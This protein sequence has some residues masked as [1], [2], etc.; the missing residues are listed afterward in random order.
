MRTLKT[1]TITGHEARGRVSLIASDDR[2]I[3]VELTDLWVAPGAPDVRLY[4]STHLDL[5]AVDS[6]IDLGPLPDGRS[7]Y[8]VPLP[9]NVDPDEVRSLIVYCT[10]YSV[11]FG[12]AHL[13]TAH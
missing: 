7:Q 10:V 2:T 1:G 3:T 11:H 12:G 9:K 4:V 6:A 5:Q 8:S 13:A